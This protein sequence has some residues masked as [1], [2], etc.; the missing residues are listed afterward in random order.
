MAKHEME[1]RFDRFVLTLLAYA[2]FACFC[3]AK[4]LCASR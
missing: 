1:E 4:S 2:P 3:N